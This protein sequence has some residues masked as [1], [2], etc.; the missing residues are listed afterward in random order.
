LGRISSIH[1]HFEVS[2]HLLIVLLYAPAPLRF[3]K[4]PKQHFVLSCIW[5]ALPIGA[6]YL[7]R[8][9]NDLR[10]CPIFNP[11]LIHGHHPADAN[12]SAA[13]LAYAHPALIHR[14]DLDHPIPMQLPARR[15]RL[16]QSFTCRSLPLRTR[17]THR[18]STVHRYC[19]TAYTPHSIIWYWIMCITRY[20]SSQVPGRSR[21]GRTCSCVQGYVIFNSRSTRM[22]SYTCRIYSSPI[23]LCRRAVVSRIRRHDCVRPSLDRGLT[24]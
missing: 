15:I 9:Y 24:L 4:H 1:P 16:C 7:P 21:Y 3:P 23:P 19:G 6:I 11:Y 20:R 12:R 10:S 5:G 2:N 13:R 22:H 17:A 8:G 14:S 18:R